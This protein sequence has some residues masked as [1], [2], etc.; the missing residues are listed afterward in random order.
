MNVGVEHAAGL[1]READVRCLHPPARMR[2]RAGLDGR[3][4]VRTRLEVARATPE[5][6]ERRI[7]RNVGAIVGRVVVATVAVGLPQLDQRVL[8]VPAVAVEHSSLDSNPL[9]R[10]SPACVNTFSPS[11]DNRIV[12]Y[13]PTVCDG[14]CRNAPPAGDVTA[15]VPLPRRTMSHR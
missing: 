13:G 10:R 4:R 3:E 5:A 12:K 2:H 7:G 6:G 9:T 15:W 1:D 8:D 11:A 14:V